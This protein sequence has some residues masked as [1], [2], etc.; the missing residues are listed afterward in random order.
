MSRQWVALE[1]I[2]IAEGHAR[3]TENRPGQKA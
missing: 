1:K 2:S 3:V